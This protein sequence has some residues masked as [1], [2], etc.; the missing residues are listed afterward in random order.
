M[1]HH[2]RK[3]DIHRSSRH[4]RRSHA[5]GHPCCCGG[6]CGGSAVG[7]LQ[8]ASR[9]SVLF[10]SQM[11]RSHLRVLIL[12]FS[13]WRRST[14]RFLSSFRGSGTSV[15]KDEGGHY[16]PPPFPMGLL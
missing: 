13:S 8:Y 7:V 4:S 3:D 14:I 16:S 11:S 15:G 10:C 2:R 6:C 5:P 1:I 12:L 9:M